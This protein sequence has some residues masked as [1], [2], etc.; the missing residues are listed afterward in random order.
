[1]KFCERP[2]KFTYCAPNGEVWPCSWMH[3]VIGNLY[4]QNMD[5]IW[6]SEAAQKARETILDGSFAYCRKIACPFLERDELPDLSE[7]ELKKVAV[8]TS[9]P[10]IFNIANDKIC[11]IA[12]T[13][14]RK[15]IYQPDVSEREQIDGALERL[16]P[17]VKKAK[18]V[19][20]N[21]QGE[22]LANPSFI[23]LLENLHPEHD[24]FQISFETNGVLF[25]RAHWERFSHLGN[26]KINVTVTINSLRR[27]VYQ[28]LS[29]GFDYLER[30]LDNMRFL[31]KLRRE[32]KI[33]Q[34]N[35]TMVVQDSNFWEVPD[36]IRTFAHSDDFEIDQIVMKPL[37]KWFKMARDTYWFKNI[38]DPNHPY[39]Q[40]YLRI[41]ADDC[42]KDPK[43]WDWGCHN[44]RK[45]EPHPLEQDKIFNRLLLD[46][47]ENSQGLSPADFM[48]T[49]LERI[50]GRRIGIYGE[51]DFTDTIVRL[52]RE[53]GA[54]V[55]FRLTRYDDCPGDPPTIS[56]P[57]F[58]PDS[59]DAI[60]LMELY[61]QQ[62]RMN[63]L[64]SLHYQ[65]PILTL[66]DLIEGSTT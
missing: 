42:W 7:D 64:R 28:Y 20:M 27:E 65:G 18:K 38:L 56:M 49:C 62:N 46:I 14:C 29:G 8:A 37:Y 51:N 17:F 32:E 25:D 44:I 45:P 59:V 40:A 57:N 50:K 4:E 41:L 63:N 3:Y 36:Y 47:F 35:V 9:T 1:M 48:K 2:F 34:L 54:E 24:D 26:Y 16:L 23:R 66:V 22:F 6:H 55:L 11:N 15:K 39:H 12:C 52:L 30:V 61:D 43:V 60:V 53:A 19:S 33:N 10:E 5:E 13:T 31:S 21:G 58:R